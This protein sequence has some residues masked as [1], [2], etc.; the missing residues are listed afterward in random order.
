MLRGNRRGR[1]CGTRDGETRQCTWPVAPALTAIG[2]TVEADGS[3]RYA[4]PK[5]LQ[6]AQRAFES[7]VPARQHKHFNKG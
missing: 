4:H 1:F 2:L 3:D 7:G 6:K 5:C